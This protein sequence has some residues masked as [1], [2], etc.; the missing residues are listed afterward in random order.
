MVGQWVEQWVAPSPHSK[1]VAGS[2]PD[3]PSLSGLRWLLPPSKD[4]LGKLSIGASVWPC[5]GFAT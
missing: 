1:T 4:G 5:N 3:C 2:N